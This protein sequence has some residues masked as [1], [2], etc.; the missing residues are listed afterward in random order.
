MI[1]AVGACAYIAIGVLV[2]ACRYGPAPQHFIDNRALFAIVDVVVWPG[3]VV[4][5]VAWH[6]GGDND[7]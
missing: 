1:F 4:A 2:A 3:H 6:L 5:W 7:A